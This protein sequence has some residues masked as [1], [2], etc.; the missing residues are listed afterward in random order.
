[1]TATLPH[2][3]PTVHTQVTKLAMIRNMHGTIAL[4]GGVS[5]TSQ[6]VNSTIRQL[7]PAASGAV[8][9]GS[10]PAGGTKFEL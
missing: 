3:R 7:A 8:S 2:T 4:P 6:Q 10:N 1:M 5:A 9:A